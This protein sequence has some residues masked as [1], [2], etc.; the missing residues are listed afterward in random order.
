[1][2]L[3]NY[4]DWKGRWIGL[5]HAFAWDKEESHARLSARY[6]RKEFTAAKVVTQATA[7]ILSGWGCT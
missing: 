4:L 2:S 6:F 3:L 1:M 5:D 7:S